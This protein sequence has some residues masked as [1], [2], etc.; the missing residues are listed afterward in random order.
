M[1]V[2]RTDRG[3]E[4]ALQSTAMN[5]TRSLALLVPLLVAMA[6]AAQTAGI[7]KPYDGRWG[8]TLVCA[9]TSDH[10]GLVKGY[11]F[12]FPVTVQ[13]GRLEGRHTEPRSSAFVRFAGSVTDD[14]A[15]V[16]EAVGET[17]VPDFTVGHVKPGTQ[18]RYS[19]KGRLGAKDGKA[20]RVELRPCTA[21]FI[22]QE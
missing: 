20:E 12:V 9:D 13:N 18:Y 5:I 14:G 1:R 8:V 3:P 2:E 10:K 19:M 4:A 6:A 15:L 22:K 16:I 7:A 11:T 17:G 21:A